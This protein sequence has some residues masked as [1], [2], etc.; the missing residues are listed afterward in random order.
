[1]PSRK[2]WPAAFLPW[3]PT[4]A[5]RG[6]SVGET[7]VVVPPAQPQA[8]CEGILRLLTSLSSAARTHQG[9][10]ARDRIVQNYS[11]NKMVGA[12]Q[13]LYRSILQEDST[14]K[15]QNPVALAG[16]C[17]NGFYETFHCRRFTN[18]FGSERFQGFPVRRPSGAGHGER[19]SPFGGNVHA[20]S[21]GGR[22]GRDI[23]CA[24]ATTWFVC[25]TN[26]RA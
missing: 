12:Y 13:T 15:R 14:G 1:M 7:G 18:P 2:P 17:R 16:V 9:V 26:S 3:R 19:R 22:W 23:G 11:F 6:T 10:L 4:S 24:S 8:F 20:S 5:M 25:S 21:F